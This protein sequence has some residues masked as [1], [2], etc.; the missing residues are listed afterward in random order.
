[1]AKIIGPLSSV[2]AAGKCGN[3]IFSRNQW[4]I[5][6]R[7]VPVYEDP[8]GESQLLWRAAFKSCADHWTSGSG[9]TAALRNMW[10]QYAKQW[11]QKD[12]YGKVI[13]LTGRD[14]FIKC[15]IFRVY[16][17]LGFHNAPTNY[18]YSIYTPS[19]SFSQDATGIYATLSAYPTGDELFFCTRVLNQNTARFFMPKNYKTAGVFTSV[20]GHPFY[21]ADNADLDSTVKRHF[22]R[23]RTI[24]GSGHP[25]PIQIL[26]LDGSRA[27]VTISCPCS[28]DNY[29][30]ES[31]P[32]TNHSTV[33]Y[34]FCY[35]STPNGER[36]LVQF[37]LSGIPGG[38]TISAA[39]L[40]LFNESGGASSTI[41]IYQMLVSWVEAQSTWNKRN[42][43]TNWGA[44]GGQSGV[45]YNSTALGSISCGGAGGWKS[46]SITTTVSAWLSG[47]LSNNGLFL[48]ETG[49]DG[50]VYFTS[51]EGT[52]SNRPYLSVTYT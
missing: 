48:I 30:D 15:M 52:S 24:D 38:S 51:K 8:E 40:Y 2:F 33:T 22:F 26:Y 19:I 3:T 1:M 37:D 45:D 23:F 41:S 13:Q 50:S 18:F 7:E 44:P 16:A 4:G 39:T 32:T 17:G 34:I 10:N 5:Y 12:N 20:D 31:L 29:L 6:A 11:P 43:T 47:S 21:V 14:V 42:S 36:S 27:P 46:L 25:S 35:K 28:A 9:M 49:A